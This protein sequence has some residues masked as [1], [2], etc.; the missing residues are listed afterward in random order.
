MTNHALALSQ[1]SHVPLLGLAAR[2]ISFSQQHPSTSVKKLEAL[3]EA[4]QVSKKHNT[5]HD[6]VF[7]T[8][9]LK[10]VLLISTV[11]LSNIVVI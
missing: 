3:A 8:N 2:R 1:L 9:L 11:L 4:V 5:P 6:V 7:T 10:C